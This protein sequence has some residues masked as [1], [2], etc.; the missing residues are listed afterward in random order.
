MATKKLRLVFL[1]VVL[2]TLAAVYFNFPKIPINFAIGSFKVDTT[3]GGDKLDWEI[4][5]LHLQR[6]LSIRRGL[7][8]Q[9]GLRV[10]LEANVDG[11]DQGARDDALESARQAVER[12]VNLFGVSEANVYSSRTASSYRIVV[13][14]PG[15]TDTEEAIELIGQTAQLDVRELDPNAA[16]GEFKFI[17]TGLTGDDL[18]RASV[19][20][21]PQSGKPQVKLEFTAEGAKKS[22]EISERNLQKTIGFFLD[23]QP[24]S[25][26][27]VQSVIEES[28]VISSD[29]FKLADAKRLAVQLNAGALPV[30]ISILS[31][32][33]IGAT[34]GSATIQKG[35]RAGLVGLVFVFL[36]MWFYYGVLGF[37]AGIGL[38]VYGLITL[39]LYRL[40]PVTL[41]FAGITG[42]LLSI[43]MAVDANILIFERYKE[44]IRAR[45]DKRIA[46][47][48]AFGRAWDSIRDANVCTLITCFILFNPFEWSFLNISGMVRGFAITLALGIA[49]GLFTGIVVTRTLI[50]L[51]YR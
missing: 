17:D 8:L 27:T 16:E 15:V 39:A 23:D 12:R 25:I 7:D 34:L 48:L 35:V 47:E 41:T 5:S 4:G 20:F 18:K 37:L 42:F 2:V 46:L 3:I 19:V 13:E 50:R 29:E 1:V 14:L 44:E 22:K 32:K 21:D 9:G 30:P 51:F 6:D 28:G 31:Q 49:V 11:V 24:L 40:V 10:I 36:F 33:Q 45:K 38:I 26:A 43:G